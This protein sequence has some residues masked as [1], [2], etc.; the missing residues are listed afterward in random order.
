MKPVLHVVTGPSGAGKSAYCRQQPDWEFC[1]YNLDD[2]AR[3]RGEVGDAHVR[4]QAWGQI[5]SEMRTGLER[6]Q[7]PI[8]LDHILDTRAITE[9]LEPA[10]AL[11]YALSLNVVCPGNSEACVERIERRK[12]TGGHGRSPQTVRQLYEDAMHVAA[13][14]SVICDRTILI[15]SSGH[16]MEIVGIVEGF[17]LEKYGET[18]PEWVVAHFAFRS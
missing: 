7:T 17:N 1:L 12:K 13:E 15:D 8:V 9:I 6:G 11:G 14:A 2:R 3:L 16:S 5:V 18:V 10:K 4:E